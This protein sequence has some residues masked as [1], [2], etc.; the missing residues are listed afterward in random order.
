MANI[1]AKRKNDKFSWGTGDLVFLDAINLPGNLESVV[2]NAPQGDRAK[3][4]YLKRLVFN[5]VIT[6]EDVI[7]LIESGAL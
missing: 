5:K 6:L 3:A 1:S 7:T 2:S 4:R